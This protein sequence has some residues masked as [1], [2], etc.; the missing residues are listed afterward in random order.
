MLV[1]PTRFV[2]D[3]LPYGRAADILSGP[4]PAAAR[5]TDVLGHLP[6]LGSTAAEQERALLLIIVGVAR[7]WIRMVHFRRRG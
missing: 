1:G 3:S 2:D 7:G 5:I 6:P 4:A